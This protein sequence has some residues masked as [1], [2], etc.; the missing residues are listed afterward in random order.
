MATPIPTHDLRKLLSEL[1]LLGTNLGIEYDT[2]GLTAA[3]GK[4]LDQALAT[5]ARL[6]DASTLVHRLRLIKS[7]EEIK[8]VR[9]A[10]KYA[11]FALDAALEHTRAGADE[12]K[13]LATM[14]A[15]VL[16]AGGDYPGNGF[17]IGSGQDAL[18]CRYK[19]G[20]RK[21]SK[22]DQLTLEWAGVSPDTMWP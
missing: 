10:A 15:A 14:Q 22:N 11:D 19:S 9:K 8:H 20:R 1:G 3:N 18:L 17:I 5:F 16:E 12:G 4:K 2:H 21:L 6:S 7:E 13:I